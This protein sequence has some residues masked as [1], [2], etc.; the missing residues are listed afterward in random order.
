[1][2]SQLNVR[3][4]LGDIFQQLLS[5]LMQIMQCRPGDINRHPP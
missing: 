3:L 1:M 5:D 2:S 4:L